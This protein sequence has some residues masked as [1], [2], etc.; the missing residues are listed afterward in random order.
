[1]GGWNNNRVDKDTLEATEARKSTNRTPD[2]KI[3]LQDYL[4]RIL[5]FIE[6]AIKRMKMLQIING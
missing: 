1:M 3:S 6:T 2:S 4:L 5:G